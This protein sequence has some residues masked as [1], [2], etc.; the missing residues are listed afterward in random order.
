MQYSNKKASEVT[1]YCVETDIIKRDVML[2][3]L[4][5]GFD[6]PRTYFLCISDA[7]ILLDST[8]TDPPF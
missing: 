5:L 4:V 2:P 8:L 6:R 3:D 1:A 7:V